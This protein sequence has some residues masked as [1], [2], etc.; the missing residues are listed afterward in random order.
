MDFFKSERFAKQ[1]AYLEQTGSTNT[2]L[3]HLATASPE[4]YPHLSVLV[5]GS[6]TAGRGRTGRSWVSP[7]GKSLS[8]S[9]LVRPTDWTMENLGWLPLVAG[10]AMRRTVQK[11]LPNSEVGLKWPNDVQVQGKKISGILSEL[12]TSAMGVVVGAGI[13][14]S[15]D[16]TELPIEG[17]TSLKLEGAT[18]TA[19]DF[20]YE[21]LKAL[22]ELTQA[23]D[24][25]PE[26][27]RAECS[28]IGQQ[29]RAIFPDGSGQVG[30]ATGIDDHGR[31]LIS[32]AGENQLLA[33]SAAD[34]QHLRHN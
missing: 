18:P 20:L 33:V 10:V 5:A 14:L 2:D 9:V 16:K 25:V 24:S 26:L 17:S 8:I 28:T 15:L 6:Q 27:V 1:F 12:L 29:V 32:V 34:I 7:A 19:D 13:N 3:V 11:F 4:K 31:L 23:F 22:A 21:Y 30:L